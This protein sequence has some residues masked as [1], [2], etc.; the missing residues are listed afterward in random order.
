MR[1]MSTFFFFSFLKTFRCY[2]T[3]RNWLRD[4]FLLKSLSVTVLHF[5]LSLLL[6]V[7]SSFVLHNKSTECATN[8]HKKG[9]LNLFRMNWRNPKK[10]G[11]KN[12]FYFF[13]LLHSQF[14]RWSENW[15]WLLGFLAHRI[16]G[17]NTTQRTFLFSNN[18]ARAAWALLDEWCPL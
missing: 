10:D 12:I 7:Y 8:S 16:Q 14:F 18:R 15:Y 1:D 11:F 5:F 3:L 4:M 13:Y 9:E 6:C 17:D 2:G